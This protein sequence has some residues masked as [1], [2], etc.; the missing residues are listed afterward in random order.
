MGAQVACKVS[1]SEKRRPLLRFNLSTFYQQKHEDLGIQSVGLTVF[2]C[3]YLFF[4]ISFSPTFENGRPLNPASRHLGGLS[5]RESRRNDTGGVPLEA[6]T[7]G[8]RVGDELKLGVRKM[9]RQ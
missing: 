1:K 4:S 3:F 9:E 5:A 8:G 2:I 6:R 7:K